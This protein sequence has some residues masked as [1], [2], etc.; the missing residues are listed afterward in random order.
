MRRPKVITFDCAE[1]L[2]WVRWNP[3]RLAVESAESVGL[4]H[5]DAASEYERRMRSRWHEYLALNQAGDEYAGRAWWS[6][7]GEEWMDGLGWPLTLAPQVVIEA[8]RRLYGEG[9]EVFGLFHDVQETLTGL[10]DREVRMAVISNWDISLRKTLEVFGI[11][12]FFEVVTAS[13][14]VGA[15]KPDPFIFQSTYEN[16]GCEA[17]QAWHVGDDPIADVQGAN[18]VGARGLLIDRQGADDG[19]H[20]FRD[21]RTLLAWYDACD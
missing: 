13:M 21:L 18:Q 9:S 10:R 5:P 1:T 15:E 12:S 17:G 20:R 14:V 3:V 7:L 2:V 19:P 11:D 6:S 8:E 16:L 4:S